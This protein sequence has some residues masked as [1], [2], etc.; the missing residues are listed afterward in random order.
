M[1]TGLVRWARNPASLLR[2]KSSSM[3]KPES[4]IPR[5]AYRARNFRMS[6]NPS[7]SGKPMSDN[8][9]SKAWSDASWSAAV[10]DETGTINLVLWPAIWK[11]F[12][13][14][15][16]HA[17]AILAEG[18]VEHASGVTVNVSRM[19]ELMKGKPKKL[20]KAATGAP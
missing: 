2:A 11:K 12:R 18:R 7:P 9:R 15:A 1:L 4:E 5:R 19:R 14:A 13:P 20:K 16:F 3:P 17:V 10:E 6:E 8:T